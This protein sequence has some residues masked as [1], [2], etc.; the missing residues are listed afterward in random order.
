MRSL[1]VKDEPENIFPAGNLK[2]IE[3]KNAGLIKHT[4]LLLPLNYKPFAPAGF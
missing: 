3:S 2:L 4:A 1:L